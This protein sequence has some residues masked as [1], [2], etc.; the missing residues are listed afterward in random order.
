[1]KNERKKHVC[2]RTVSNSNKRKSRFAVEASKINVNSNFEKSEPSESEPSED[3]QKIHDE[4]L[5]ITE[6]PDANKRRKSKA[7]VKILETELEA[8]PHWTN[9]DM[10]K[11]AKKTGLTKS[12]V[13]KWNW[14]QK[15]KL[16]ILPRK[17][18]V[19]QLPSGMVVSKT[20]QIILKSPD[21]LKLL[22]EQ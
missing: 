20:G 3:N 4:M 8:K 9:E 19:V 13:Y 1:M 5:K 16:N 15:K 10:V 2:Y 6:D 12:Q 7:Q 11:I 14:D 18:Y 22:S 17:V 21:D